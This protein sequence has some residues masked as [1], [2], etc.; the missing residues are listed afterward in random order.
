[1]PT[2]DITQYSALG[3]LLFVV[4]FLTVKGVPAGVTAV[5]DSFDKLITTFEKQIQIERELGQT[6]L[7]DERD[8]NSKDLER[9]AAAIDRL[10]T[11]HRSNGLRG[12]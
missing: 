3:V 7:K 2:S 4:V 6:A 11:K 5:K 9:L 1:M 8:T 10:E 12:A